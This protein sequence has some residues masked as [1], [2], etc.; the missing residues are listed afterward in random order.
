MV[1]INFFRFMKKIKKSCWA[2]GSL[3]LIKWGK[4][5]NKQRYKC[6]N[7][8]VLSTS[9]NKSVSNSNR[10]IW[11]KEWVVGRRTISQLS[12]Q[13]DYSE[14]TLK[15]YF[16]AYLSQA[17]VFK[18]RPSEK[19]NLLFPFFIVSAVLSACLHLYL[20]DT[21]RLQCL[22]AILPFYYR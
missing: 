17:P 4:R 7:C 8:G 21:L 2:C 18:V 12:S 5:D 11:F 15:R 20:G 14:R 10:F 1:S 19:V 16:H 13:S 3:Y 6:N 9:S 22:A